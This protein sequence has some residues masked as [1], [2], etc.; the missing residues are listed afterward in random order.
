MRWRDSLHGINP[1]YGINNNM[2]VSAAIALSRRQ[3]GHTTT[4]QVSDLVYVEYY[5]IA[6]KEI[7]SRL[8][9]IDN[10]YTWQQYTVDT[11]ANQAEYTMPL[12]S[13]TK[14]WLKRILDVYLKDSAWEYEKIK[15]IDVDG[16]EEDEQYYTNTSQPFYSPRDGSIFIYPI[17]TTAVTQWL[18]C[19]WTYIPL[20]VTIATTSADVKLPEEYHPI[21][22]KGMNMWVFDEKRLLND[23]M[24]AKNEYEL[25]IKNMK[26]ESTRY[27][28]WPYTGSEPD[29]SD[30]E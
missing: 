4:W 17:P 13:S 5:N 28:D 14:T 29:L 18:K 10:R 21:I 16:I 8:T 6:Q 7:F 20:D 22:I 27:E 1:L 11:V 26:V 23:K 25:G 24:E 15:S 12:P 2:D 19:T 30:L 3:T 9:M